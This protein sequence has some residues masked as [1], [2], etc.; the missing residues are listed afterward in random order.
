M[1]NIFLEYQK[2]WIEDKSPVKVCAK[3]RRIGLTWAESADAVLVASME[4][5]EGGM[6]Y[7]YISTRVELAKEFIDTCSDWVKWI[8]PAECIPVNEAIVED[9]GKAITVYTINFASGHTV[10]ALSSN[11]SNMRGMQGIVAIDEAAHQEDLSK[12]LKA[13]MAML[14]WGGKVRIISTHHGEA[15]EF[16][17]IIKQIK[18]N[19]LNFSYHEYPIDR[20][21]DDG[22]YKRI[23]KVSKQEWSQ[24]AQEQW[25]KDLVASYGEH[26]A[27]EL[28]CHP[29]SLSGQFFNRDV[30]E[31]CT[32]P[33]FSVLRLVCSRDFIQKSKTEQLK[34]I[35]D[36]L[37]NNVYP[38]IRSLITKNYKTYAGLDFGRSHDLTVLSILVEPINKDYHV[39]LMLEL[40]NCPFHCQ[41]HIVKY[42]LSKFK[43]LRKAAFDATG[44]G[45]YLAE[46]IAM[47][48]GSHRVEQVK[49]SREEY[50]SRFPRYKAALE[51]SRLRIP[52]DEDVV[53]DHLTVQIVDGVPKV[54]SNMEFVGQDNLPRHGDSVISLMLAWS[55]TPSDHRNKQVRVWEKPLAYYD[56]SA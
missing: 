12:L 23:C 8:M 4:K 40:R 32:D 44:N 5:S 41:A 56:Y 46:E 33:A 29:S 49:L 27:E 50:L 35:D 24:E 42:V 31:S 18:A 15:N 17:T 14:M 21:L 7:L 48:F 51:S 16:N 52:A 22:L 2:D 36:W 10:Y 39:P 11:P 28:Y 43:R 38:Y 45:S 3:S 13:A 34:V 19:K 9:E 47:E 53:D 25:L 20:A 30:V 37:T 26:A 6:D 54:P 55:C 1:E